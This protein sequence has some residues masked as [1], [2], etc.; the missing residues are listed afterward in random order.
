MVFSEEYLF[1]LELH[2]KGA[3]SQLGKAFY[4]AH[5]YHEI[6]TVIAYYEYICMGFY[7]CYNCEM[8][9]TL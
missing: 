3:R 8:C 9:C 4:G 7:V 2:F 6:N 5:M 1:L